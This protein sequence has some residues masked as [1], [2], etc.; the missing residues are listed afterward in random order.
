MLTARIITPERLKHISETKYQLIDDVLDNVAQ[1]D[2]MFREEVVALASDL[3]LRGVLRECAHREIPQGW[4]SPESL[5]EHASP[6]DARKELDFK[7]K[8][9]ERVVLEGLGQL[10]GE[11]ISPL[12]D[13]MPTLYCELNAMIKEA[14]TEF[15]SRHNDSWSEAKLCS[16]GLEQNIRERLEELTAP[17]SC[18]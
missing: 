12:Q 10:F 18:L 13:A 14:D 7:I 15:K 2:K 16:A 6:N 8:N 11:A 17:P 5:P 3:T 9:R 1:A 4:F